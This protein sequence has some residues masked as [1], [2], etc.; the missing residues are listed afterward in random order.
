MIGLRRRRRRDKRQK[1]KREVAKGWGG[2]L[3]NKKTRRN[4]VGVLMSFCV[5]FLLNVYYQVIILG[6]A[7]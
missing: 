4:L 2:I 1:K 7:F 3:P 6:H 5:V